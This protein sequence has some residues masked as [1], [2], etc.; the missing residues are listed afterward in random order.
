MRH[1]QHGYIT[2]LNA[3]LQRKV[4][5]I[6]EDK[7]SQDEI[8][9]RLFVLTVLNASMYEARRGERRDIIKSLQAIMNKYGTITQSDIEALWEE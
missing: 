5:E 4:I 9:E 7:L 1:Q 2:P 8:E 6:L 3:D